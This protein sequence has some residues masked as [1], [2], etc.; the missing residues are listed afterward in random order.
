MIGDPNL[1]RACS[2]VCGR[3]KGQE[4]RKSGVWGL[5]TL[6][7]NFTRHFLTGGFALGQRRVGARCIHSLRRSVIQDE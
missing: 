6:D 3:G 7:L 5:G 2:D 1:C 4:Q